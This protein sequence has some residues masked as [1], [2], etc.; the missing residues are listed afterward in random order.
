MRPLGVPGGGALPAPRCSLRQASG[1]A[2]CP[3]PAH[4]HRAATPSGPRVP[5]GAAGLT[6]V[7]LGGFGPVPLGFAFIPQSPSPGDSP[8]LTCCPAAALSRPLALG[9]PVADSLPL[10]AQSVTS[11]RW[12]GG[13]ARA[14]QV[15]V[16]PP[17]TSL[18]SFHAWCSLVRGRGSLP[19]APA[20]SLGLPE[21]LR[22]CLRAQPYPPASAGGRAARGLRVPSRGDALDATLSLAPPFPEISIAPSTALCLSVPRSVCRVSVLTRHRGQDARLDVPA[23]PPSPIP[24]VALRPLPPEL[25]CEVID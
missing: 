8:L 2:A 24:H 14:P 17:R 11:G 13:L 22:V 10:A 5:R 3:P 4:G 12:P 1:P 19:G 6:A 18:P 21:P 23:H 25:D 16:R 7:S 15:H 9:L 20:V